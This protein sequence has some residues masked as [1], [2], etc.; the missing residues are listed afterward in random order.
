MESGGKYSFEAILFQQGMLGNTFKALGCKNFT[1][2]E[3]PEFTIL[4]LVIISAGR[5]SS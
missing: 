4:L 2:L 1:I 3:W 5:T